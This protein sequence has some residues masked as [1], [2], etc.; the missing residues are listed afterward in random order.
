ME[1]LI[2]QV[3]AAAGLPSGFAYDPTTARSVNL[4]YLLRYDDGGRYVVRIYRWPF[5][6]PDELDRPTKETW[7][8]Q[9]LLDHG[10]PVGRVLAKAESGQG[11]A[12]LRSYLPGEPL[13]ALPEI[14]D[15]AWRSVGESLARVHAI[16]VGEGAA[17][18]I[19]PASR[20]SVPRGQL[21]SLA[22][23]ECARAQ[24]TGG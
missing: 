21:G 24:P 8:S 13:G 16:R 10:V 23:G 4:T 20:R 9:V 2:R 1:Q 3:V 15:E 11:I 14:Y 5:D 7:L 22:T 6:G 12:V 18:V 19:S 17:G